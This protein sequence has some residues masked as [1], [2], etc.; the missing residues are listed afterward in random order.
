MALGLPWN[1][2]LRRCR[3]VRFRL[4]Q[5]DAHFHRAGIFDHGLIQAP[6]LVR[7]LPHGNNDTAYMQ[8]KKRDYVT[9]TVSRKARS[10]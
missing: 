7:I 9:E 2:V 3:P 5:R 8:S 6:L 1:S 10:T 4:L